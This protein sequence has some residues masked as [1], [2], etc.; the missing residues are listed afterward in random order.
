MHSNLFN[1]SKILLF[2]A[3]FSLVIVSTSTLFPFI[4]GKY[5][6]FKIV[7]ELALISFILGIGFSSNKLDLK[8]LLFDWFKSPLVI[9]V[10]AFVFLFTLS[11]FTGVNP[12]ASFWSNF[13]RGEGS[14]LML[15]F[16]VYFILLLALFSNEKDWRHIFRLS[17]ISGI[18]VMF[19][20]ILGAMNVRGV[21]GN[22][23]C[24]RFAGSLGN[25]A[26][27]GTLSIFLLFYVMYFIAS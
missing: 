12:S 15:H 27:I 17:I 13:E 7:I 14:F 1:F 6:F 16:Y 3:P 10:T 21:V 20:G 26:Y 8:K 18:F 23:I 9:A 4:V 5:T 2:I 22:D 19:Y 25:P 24:D 11:G